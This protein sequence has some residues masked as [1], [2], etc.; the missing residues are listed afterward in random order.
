MAIQ[1]LDAGDPG[2]VLFVIELQLG[3]TAASGQQRG[4]CQ[5]DDESH[6]IAPVQGL[7]GG[8]GGVGRLGRPLTSAAYLSRL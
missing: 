3:R 4:Q 6:V 2:R 1:S 8:V 7:D 5:G